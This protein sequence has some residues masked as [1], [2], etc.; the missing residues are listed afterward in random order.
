MLPATLHM[1]DRFGQSMTS[2]LPQEL[3]VDDARRA[4]SFEAGDLS[5][6]SP[7]GKP[8]SQIAIVYG[9]EAQAVPPPGLVRLG[10]VKAGLDAIASAARRFTMTIRRGA[11]GNQVAEHWIAWRSSVDRRAGRPSRRDLRARVLSGPAR[12]GKASARANREG[13]LT[14]ALVKATVS[15]ADSATP[16]RSSSPAP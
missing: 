13:R 11:S 5:Y 8:A 9:A 7:T 3:D 15:R 16:S 1:E 2:R 10:S 14:V 12:R 4:F 6:W